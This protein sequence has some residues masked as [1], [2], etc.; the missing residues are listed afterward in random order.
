MKFSAY[1]RLI[2][3]DIESI[4]IITQPFERTNQSRYFDA[5][6]NKRKKCKEL[7]TAFDERLSASFPKARIRIHNGPNETIALAYA[8]MIMAKQTIVGIGTFGVFP[9]LATFG[10]G[11]IRKPDYAIAPNRWLLYPP[12]DELYDNVVLFEEPNRLMTYQV[13]QLR[14]L[15]GRDENVLE[16][17]RNDTYCIDKCIT[18][19]RA[20]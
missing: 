6:E 15:P 9:A 13:K 8:R 7:V 14:K 3:P 5:T 4:G 17:F 10:T 1:T 18:T 11:Y 2:S 19:S 20:L 16:W 12:A